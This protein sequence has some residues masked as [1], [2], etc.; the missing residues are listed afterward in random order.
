MLESDLR[1]CVE[2]VPKPAVIQ[3]EFTASVDSNTI[4]SGSN[5]KFTLSCLEQANNMCCVSVEITKYEPF[6]WAIGRD[7]HCCV[8]NVC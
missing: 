7:S 8:L 6:V 3:S 5:H 4:R 2:S 1:N